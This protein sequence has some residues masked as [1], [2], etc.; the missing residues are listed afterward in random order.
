MST[1]RGGPRAW[2]LVLAAGVPLP[3]AA[4]DS[5][6]VP[7]VPAPIE[8]RLPGEVALDRGRIL[9]FPA[10]GVGLVIDAAAE[11]GTPVD[12]GDPL[13]VFDNRVPAEAAEAA[14]SDLA[15]AEHTLRLHLLEGER[16]VDEL[17]DR[18]RAAE[19]ALAQVEAAI[20]AQPTQAAADAALAQAEAA[21]AAVQAQAQA[22]AASRLARESAAGM[23]SAMA[24]EDQAHA[25]AISALQAELPSLRARAAAAGDPLA[26][27]EL[28]LRRRQLLRSLGRRDDGTSDPAT[29]L[30][31]Q[32]RAMRE[33]QQRR[34]E[35]DRLACERAAQEL[36]RAER[37]AFDCTPL[38]A[39][40]VSSPAWRETRR[41]V[42]AP[43]GASAPA[44]AAVDHGL[45]YDARRGWGWI[46]AAPAL[47][48]C[49]GLS[50]PGVAMIRGTA[51]WRLQVP[52]GPC[53]I[54]V[55]IGDEQ[56]WYG[57]VVRVRSGN[58]PTHPL[59]ACNA[60]RPA[61]VREAR[62]VVTARGGTLEVVIGDGAA[63][64]IRAPSPGLALRRP[65]IGPGWRTT[66]HEDP[67]AFFATGTGVSVQA[68]IPIRWA[69]A[70]RPRDAGLPTDTGAMAR[71][72]AS[73]AT[74]HV[75]IITPT[76][77]SIEGEVQSVIDQ[78]VLPWRA[79]P[80]WGRDVPDPLDG[81][82]Y[83]VRIAVDPGL[84][85]LLPIGAGVEV[86][87]TIP[88]P[89]TA[90]VTAVPA[91]LATLADHACLIAPAGSAPEIVPGF[92]LGDRAVLLKSLA[93]GTRLVPP[94]PAA[95]PAQAAIPGVVIAGARTPVA[96]ESTWGRIATLVPEGTRVEAGQVVVTLYNPSLEASR[97]QRAQE[98][99][100]AEEEYLVQAETRHAMLVDAAERWREQ[101]LAEEQ[102]RLDFARSRQQPA[103]P[104][105]EA[106]DALTQAQLE[107]RHALAVSVALHA[108]DGTDAGRLLDADT[109]V[110]TTAIA[111]QRA[112]LAL[113]QASLAGD[114]LA[115]MQARSSWLE[116]LAVLDGREEDVRIARLQDRIAAASAH[117]Q[118]SRTLAGSWWEQ[119]FQRVRE[120]R[121]RSSGRLFYL[122]GWN[123]Q[124]SRIGK[125]DR[126]FYV[127]QGLTVAEV[128]D[129]AHLAFHAEVPE[130]C[131]RRLAVGTAVT[132]RFPGLEDARV[133][134][135]ITVLG[136]RFHRADDAAPADPAAPISDQ[137]TVA[138]DI[139]FD[140]PPG[141]ADRLV[142]GTPGEV[143]L[144]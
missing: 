26:H 128:L 60:L 138:V 21:I 126:D 59:L 35:A 100:Q 141:I 82:A 142:P 8:L 4:L 123:D 86:D 37:D 90:G 124:T 77:T 81:T 105:G 104:Q 11:D 52:E 101:E 64:A 31:V 22:R 28:L 73:V 30:P 71:A 46:G 41:F 38:L 110:R 117:L 18:Q 91:H 125:F 135:R 27:E 14:R 116:A 140:P 87:G 44:G 72:R 15:I 122:N 17:V 40:E 95:P 68:R 57:Q 130:R 97:D 16:A 42:F 69:S 103:G 131:W 76:G 111:E 88:I 58:G 92:L 66:S 34:Q 55:R 74:S 3:G 29:G 67:A 114:L 120:L 65:W 98:H 127:W 80:T 132:L 61:E 121:A 51:T 2:L 113:A 112:Q 47:H 54:T 84:A 93:P 115:Q 53:A 137:R 12:L 56:D 1:S 78:P 50:A 62:A 107:H 79:P 23:A 139:A 6:R 94:P 118:L 136:H 33:E 36:H 99:R 102:A 63:R 19:S 70:L 96:L 5:W 133:R 144:P 20:A 49:S 13:V 85:A 83:L 9:T 39:V 43:E 48:A 10:N 134:G 109:K 75:R 119:E 45:P 24:A 32:I 106:S 89:A 7:A 108:I 25:A 129:M 143:E